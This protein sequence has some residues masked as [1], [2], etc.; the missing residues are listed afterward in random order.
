MMKFYINISTL[1]IL[2][3]FS[4]GSKQKPSPPVTVEDK[5]GTGDTM[6]ALLAISVYKKLD[7]NFC[8]FLSAIAAAHNIKYM[9]NKLPLDKIYITKAIQSYLK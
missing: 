3:F 8:M 7:I 2:L 6:L 9:A 4:C 1:I 5:V